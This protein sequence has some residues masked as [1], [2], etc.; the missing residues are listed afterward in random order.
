MGLADEL[1]Q[2]LDEM[3]GKNNDA[4]TAPSHYVAGRTYEPRRVI[5]DWRL[6]FNLGN[7][8]KYIARDGR[9]DNAIRD[10]L[11]ARQYLDFEI[12]DL[13]RQEYPDDYIGYEDLLQQW[14][15]NNV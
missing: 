10:L 5:A 9:K 8:V 4:I 11:K 6:N 12:E 1:R 3:D 14:R 15:I 13:L 7:V 2:R